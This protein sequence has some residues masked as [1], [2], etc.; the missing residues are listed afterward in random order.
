MGE[1]TAKKI[2][3]KSDQKNLTL[4]GAAKLNTL[5]KT[6]KLRT[7]LTLTDSLIEQRYLEIAHAS[8]Y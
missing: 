5:R 1:M 7:F 4:Y 2:A 8:I 6:E 3:R